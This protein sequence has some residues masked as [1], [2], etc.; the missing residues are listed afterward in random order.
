ME[1]TVFA[2]QKSEGG[3]FM[4]PS[5]QSVSKTLKIMRLIF[6]F[7]L[8]GFLQLSANGVSQTVSIAGK[9]MTLKKVISK[10]RSETGYDFFYL[11]N[12]LKSS[13]PVSVNLVNVPLEK[14]LKICFAGQPFEYRLYEKVIIIKPRPDDKDPGRTEML[15][16]IPAFVPVRG[17]VRNENGEPMVGATVTAK[18]MNRS[19]VTDKNGVFSIDVP[20]GSTLVISSVGYKETEHY[21]SES[22]TD[23]SISL[24]LLNTSLDEVVVIG[25]GTVKKRDLTGSVASVKADVITKAPTSNAIEAIQGRVT[26]MDYGK[27]ADGETVIRIRG[28]RSIS[29]KNDPLFII[30]GLQGGSYS[31]ISP[32][33]IESI[34]VL[35]DASSTAIYGYQ[36]A[37]GVIIITTKKGKAGQTRIA[38]NSFVG[39]DMIPSLP[40]YR[41]GE[42]WIAPRREAY[43]SV[44]QWN[45]PADDAGLFPNTLE[46]DAYKAGI[47]TNYDDLLKQNAIN[48]SHQITA[49]GGNDKTSA[50]LSI[51]YYDQQEQYKL[52]KMQRYTLRTN[53]DHKIRSWISTGI[54]FQATHNVRKYSPYSGGGIQLGSPYDD[55]GNLVDYP[56]GEQ[57]YINPLINN[58]SGNNNVRQVQGTGLVAQGYLNFQLLDGLSFRSQLGTTLSFRREGSFDAEHSTQQLQAGFSKASMTTDNNRFLNWDNILTY[59]KDIKDHSLT[60]TGLSS[61]TQ[62]KAESLTGSGTGQI[63]PNQL[64]Y[65]LGANDKASFELGSQYTQSQTFSYAFRANYS[66]KGRYLLTLSDRFDGASRLAEGN[67]WASFPSAALGWRMGDEAFMSSTRSWLDELKWRVTYGVTGNSG[68][69]EYGTQSGVESGTN[70]GFQDSAVTYYKFK[71]LLGNLDLGWEKS[72]MFNVGLDFSLL[73]G[74]INTSIDVY[75]TNTRDLLLARSLP[76]SL[77]SEG[78]KMFQ[79]IGK[80]N[81]KGIEVMIQSL[82]I[83]KGDFTWG[84]TVTFSKNKEKIVDLIDGKDILA[85]ERE[86]ESLLIG[87]PVRSYYT[88]VR[89]GIWQTSEADKAAALFKDPNKTNPFKPGDIKVRDL[90]G[91]DVITQDKDMMYIGSDVPD[92]Y[93]GFNNTFSYKNFDL[94]IFMY[95]RYGQ[96]SNSNPAASYSPDTG[97]A[98][99]N[100]DYWTPENPS[101]DLPRPIKGGRLFDYIGYQSYTFTDGSFFKLKNIT[102]SYRL[103]N[104][105]LS[106]ARIT[107]FRVYATGTNLLSVNR[108]HFLKYRDAEGQ[109][110]QYVLGLNLE[111]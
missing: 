109:A 39:V 45:S 108:S 27:N 59:Q 85:K 55:E 4:R 48:Q 73:N 26:G 35:K 60:L 100:L 44:N 106:N 33:D 52:G 8:A 18:G 91:D 20:L 56:L 23:I 77:G 83:K 70:L 41:Q 89:E 50:R 95:F 105:I 72:Y 3:S 25:F 79:N 38:Y 53:V 101:N 78:F 68:I 71:P 5:L 82:N 63:A 81:N 1:L 67:K 76:T 40:D 46:W 104:R 97:G 57:A 21:V 36:G 34:E 28:N 19:V 54:N 90:D 24:S 51:T 30:D 6:I 2:C 22:T 58:A 98:F 10:I 62:G 64:F 49:S 37:N 7:L 61:W 9:D 86:Q 42:N 87:R 32:N 111:F 15:A 66:Y 17:T 16:E 75:N 80:T 12:W 14:A 107:N 94:S 92:W 31:D 93:T 13:K 74:R 69:D 102:L 29:G 84:S 99:A 11:N 65:N 103:P 43:R 47:W 110:R 96:F 88:F